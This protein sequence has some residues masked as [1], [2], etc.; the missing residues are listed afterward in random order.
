M[1]AG[2][3]ALLL[4][5]ALAQAASFDE[6]AAQAAAQGGDARA[7]LFTRMIEAVPGEPREAMR[8]LWMLFF[9]A[10]TGEQRGQI[11]ERAAKVPSPETRM[12]IKT[13]QDE[14]ELANRA[15]KVRSAMNDLLS[16]LPGA[17]G[18]GEKVK[19]ADSPFD[20]KAKFEKF[21]EPPPWVGRWAGEGI[22]ID[23]NVFPSGVVAGKL[24]DA[25]TRKTLL[26]VG[27]GDSLRLIGNELLVEWKKDHFETNGQPLKKVAVGLA[28][29]RPPEGATILLSDEVAVWQ[30]KTGNLRWKLSDGIMEMLPGVQSHHSMESFGD[31]R[32]YL[33]FRHAYNPDA[34]FGLRGNSGIYLQSNYEIQMTEA[35][36]ADPKDTL[37]GALYRVKAPGA[38]AVAPPMEWQSMEIE[39]RCPRFD[40]AGKKTANAKVTVWQNGKKIH[41]GAEF[42]EVGGGAVT[43]ETA[44]PQPI[45]IQ[46]HGGLL[47]FRNIWAERLKVQPAS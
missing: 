1:K 38:V 16:T 14:P 32:V 15:N 24:G 13:L 4:A 25:L 39:F 28:G 9:L 26:G 20:N 2:L 21:E 43:K 36:G 17:V 23:V 11:L 22:Q 35:F 30:E 12:L 8:Q 6:M 47:Q 29:K 42:P 18:K 37:S 45:L 19:F 5:T 27:S 44:E 34:A 7:V 31:V 40:P 41:E 3:V 33:E 46:A 10:E